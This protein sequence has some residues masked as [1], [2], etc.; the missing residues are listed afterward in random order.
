MLWT[1]R[2]MLVRLVEVPGLIREEFWRAHLRVSPQRP[3]SPVSGVMPPRSNLCFEARP[4]ELSSHDR[5][6][7]GL[8]CQRGSPREI[9]V[10]YSQIEDS[11]PG[12]PRDLSLKDCSRCEK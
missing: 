1:F 5:C 2:D 4:T 6:S 7:I 9:T 12:F 10:R 3:L 11:R 8:T